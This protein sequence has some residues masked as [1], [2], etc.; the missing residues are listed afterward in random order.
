MV[1]VAV[2]V[3]WTRRV[4]VGL[5]AVG[6]STDVG[7]TGGCWVGGCWCCWML[8]VGTWGSFVG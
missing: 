7:L 8:D 1:R 2:V 6:T 4:A 5:G 3:A